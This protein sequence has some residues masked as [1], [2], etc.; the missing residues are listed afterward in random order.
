[1]KLFYL[2]IIALLSLFSSSLYAD[3]N[4]YLHQLPEDII[5]GESSAPITVIEYS[6][7]S[8]PA[9]GFFHEDVMPEIEGKYIATGKVK[10]IF[11]NYP[12]HQVDIK[13]AA[14]ALCGGPERYYIFI[15]ALFRTQKNWARETKHGV[16]V[17]ENIAKMGGLSGDAI[18]QCLEDKA[19]ENKIIETRQL[20]QNQLKINATPT[21]IINGK[22][23]ADSISKKALINAIELSLNVNK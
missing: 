2:L 5:L 12:M 15:K 19:L 4:P 6:S 3:N 21:L 13:A 9:C 20:A 22:I 23:Y 7:L 11:R 10:F 8:C 18:K 16:E 17:L 1:M 14:T